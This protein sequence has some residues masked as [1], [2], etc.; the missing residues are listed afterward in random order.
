MKLSRRSLTAAAAAVTAALLLIGTASAQDPSVP[1]GP[2]TLPDTIG[3]PAKAHPLANSRAPQNPFLAPNPYSHPH[4]DTWNSDTVDIAA[5]LGRDP[6]VR[7]STLASVREYPGDALFNCG[8]MAF[9]RH[10]RIISRRISRV[11]G[12]TRWASRH[13]LR[14]AFPVPSAV[15][16]KGY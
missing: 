10:G 13:D 5:P 3:A 2:R 11:N 6:E 15:P 12:E 4:N 8:T 14:R 1:S 16:P 9:D 7:S